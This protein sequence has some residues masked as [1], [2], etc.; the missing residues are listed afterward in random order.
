MPRKATIRSRRSP[1]SVS[2]IDDVRKYDGSWLICIPGCSG[3][4]VIISL[5]G[6]LIDE[7]TGTEFTEDE[8]LQISCYDEDAGVTYK[9]ID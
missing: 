2:S 4:S 5:K 8:I 6:K 7:P 1:K 3:G 9:R